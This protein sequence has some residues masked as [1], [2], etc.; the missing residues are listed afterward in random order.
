MT[1]LYENNAFSI[2]VLSTKKLCSSFLK[3]FLFSRKFVSKFNYSKRT[4][5]TDC[6]IETCR[7]LK[8]RATFQKRLVGEPMLFLL[9]LK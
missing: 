7:S 9:A 1:V 6:H 2:L 4:K 8:R 5:L 3:G